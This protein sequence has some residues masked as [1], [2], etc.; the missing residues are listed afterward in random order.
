M[1]AVKGVNA[2]ID[3]SEREMICVIYLED[4][5]FEGPTLYAD[6]EDDDGVD[7]YEDEIDDFAMVYLMIL[8]KPCL[9]IYSSI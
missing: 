6:E 2:D 8:I 9:F 4:E 1:G 7:E 3:G 5:G